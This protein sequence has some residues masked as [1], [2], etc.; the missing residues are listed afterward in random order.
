MF[1]LRIMY[2]Q[3]PADNFVIMN[4]PRGPRLARARNPD[5]HSIL[6]NCL[7]KI[8]IYCLSSFSGAQLWPKAISGE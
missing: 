3:L 1:P 2:V 8:F 5:R 7:Y 4:Q 6:T